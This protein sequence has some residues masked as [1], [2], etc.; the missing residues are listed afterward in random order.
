MCTFFSNKKNILIILSVI[1]I[2]ITALVILGLTTTPQNAVKSLYDDGHIILEYEDEQFYFRG[3]DSGAFS[4]SKKI[5]FFWTNDHYNPSG[6]DT[7]QRE[8]TKA[9]DTYYFYGKIFKPN[10]NNVASVVLISSYANNFTPIKP[11]ISK[12]TDDYMLFLFKFENPG[13]LMEKIAFI[14]HDGSIITD[15]TS[16]IKSYHIYDIN[17][18]KQ[19]QYIFNDNDNTGFNKIFNDIINEIILNGNRV[20]NSP[21]NT[22]DEAC[23]FKTNTEHK[24]YLYY[25]KDQFNDITYSE[26]Y[27]LYYNNNK[28]I[29]M[30][31]KSYYPYGTPIGKFSVYQDTT[32]YEIENTGKVKEFVD[33]C[34]ELYK[35]NA[36]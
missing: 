5:L 16:E 24:V 27:S 19:P 6:L 10:I 22:N 31:D 30:L 11:V 20:Y 29:L 9:G 32:Y 23:F 8:I 34:N 4:T 14:D 2:L 7:Y 25:I 17:G 3:Y 28:I 13:I 36:S 26:E 21:I 1:F 12:A 35:K 33:M 18:K 15:N